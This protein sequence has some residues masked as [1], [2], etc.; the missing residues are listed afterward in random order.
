MATFDS[1]LTTTD[2]RW[3]F[4][5]A[6]LQQCAAPNNFNTRPPS[7]SHPSGVYKRVD[8]LQNF[9]IPD[10]L[11]P[12]VGAKPSTGLVLWFPKRPTSSMHHM[13]IIP[14]DYE[15][16]RSP[17]QANTFYSNSLTNCAQVSNVPIVDGTLITGVFGFVFQ[18]ALAVPRL[19]LPLVASPALD[20]EF[21]LTRVYGGIIRSWSNSLP[22]GNTALNGNCSTATVS[23]TRDIAQSED[24]SDAFAVV[25]M[26]QS[27]RTIK[28]IAKNIRADIG[29][30][31][32]QGPDISPTYEAPNSLN[33]VR[34]AGGWARPQQFPV[35]TK[36]VSF[37]DDVTVAVGQFKQIP[38]FGAW[39]SPWGVQQKEGV[40]SDFGSGSYSGNAY[41]IYP[42]APLALPTMSEMGT[43]EVKINCG[44]R[45]RNMV[46]NLDLNGYGIRFYLVVE[47]WFAGISNSATGQ[48]MTKVLRTTQ[49]IKGKI[50]DFAQS[51]SVANSSQLQQPDL[52]QLDHISNIDQEYIE[53]GGLDA[54][55]KF[56]GNKILIC[57]ATG[58]A[59]VGNNLTFTVDLMHEGV[60]SAK[61]YSDP[62]LYN[63]TLTGPSISF[64]ASDINLEGNCGPCHI[65]RYEEIGPGQN[66]RIQAMLNTES[67]AKGDLAPYVQDQ[68]MNSRIAN[69]VNVLPLVWIMF[70]GFSGW[71]TCFA[72]D[73]YDDFVNEEIK[74]MTAESL[75]AMADGDPRIKTS[76]AAA[77]LF[78]G[79][80]GALGNTVG[81]LADGALGILG[82]T[83]Q[84]GADARGQF[85]AA[86]QFG[87]SGPFGNTGRLVAGTYGNS[88]SGSY[89][90]TASLFDSVRRQRNQ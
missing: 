78:G 58:W 28:D 41:G 31:N 49:E 35:I 70:N 87:A 68:V 55:G 76:M 42:D 12:I 10:A 66:F 82:A 25:D 53:Q 2:P 79:I 13:G 43:V 60:Q 26:A 15:L 16:V 47:H 83:G 81:G 73:Q 85:G 18:N 77:G 56:I 50:L 71:T 63:D 65:T 75:V 33:N 38:L 45:I 57:C 64:F 5:K 17:D 19:D 30:V 24:G 61:T 48:I 27:A 86:G 74:P 51:S 67:V 14:A 54:M 4:N 36:N 59:G 22:I 69:D 62:L 20:K 84:Y 23:D 11:V 6:F 37:T 21:S 39:F 88:A 32:I 44:V 9:T 29:V 8:V 34:I 1:S 7:V 72:A 52:N 40:F 3:A 90:G 46:S 89:N 80:L